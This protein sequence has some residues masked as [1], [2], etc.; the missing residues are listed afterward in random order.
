MR[1][2]QP[3]QISGKFRGFAVGTARP[4]QLLL[5]FQRPPG[6]RQQQHLPGRRRKT[7]RAGIEKKLLLVSR[8]IKAQGQRSGEFHVRH[9]QRIA[10]QIGHQPHKVGG[11][12]LLRTRVEY[13]LEGA[14]V[15]PLH[16]QIE[17]PG[18]Q[19]RENQQADAGGSAAPS[20][21][22]AIPRK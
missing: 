13:A 22:A 11:W 8:L 10:V 1:A 21:N 16:R 2:C 4:L 17:G 14:I 7:Q 3:L 20:S 18:Q 19:Y 15:R 12:Q 9:Q 6:Q 5:G